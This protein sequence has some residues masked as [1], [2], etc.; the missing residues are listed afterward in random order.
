MQKLQLLITCITCIIFIF[1]A[2]PDKAYATDSSDIIPV[3]L[4][5]KEKKIDYIR[6][7]TPVTLEKI[8]LDLNPEDKWKLK[9]QQNGLMLQQNRTKRVHPLP[10][11]ITLISQN[12]SP[13]CISSDNIAKRC[14]HGKINIYSKQG[15]LQLINMVPVINYL[16]SAVGS[17]LLRGWPDEAVKAQTVASHSYLLYTLSQ[18]N[19]IKDSTQSQFYGGT[20]YE[21]TDYKSA[22]DEVKDVVLLD[23]NNMP[24]EALF[25]ST[26]AG[27]TLNNEDVFGREPIS[28]LRSTP[29]KYCQDSYFSKTKVE[30]IEKDMLKDIFKTDQIK[31]IHKNDG[32]LKSIQTSHET[33]TPYQG[34]LKIGQNLN[35]G[36]VPGVKYNINCSNGVCKLSSKG[37]GHAVG[38]CQWGSK[39]M[40]KMGYKYQEILRYYYK[41]VFFSN[42]DQESS[43]LRGFIHNEGI[44]F[45]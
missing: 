1:I 29:C 19:I 41:N 22:I 39:G 44:K 17:E 37:A 24:I 42:I 33:L 9:A 38:M 45:R 2:A 28:Y 8:K 15:K 30:D 35:W 20:R 23:E 31:I 14:Y 10:E 11:K 4:F 36:I 13:I 16:Y 26:C 7:E 6:I 25:H 3:E 5:S 40:A 43:N 32:S 27:S 21:N 18:G 12:N 34:W